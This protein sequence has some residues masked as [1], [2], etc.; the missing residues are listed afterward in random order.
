M[1]IQQLLNLIN[2]RYLFTSRPN[3]VNN[4]IFSIR[5]D[6]TILDYW[7]KVCLEDRLVKIIEHLNRMGPLNC[8]NYIR[9]MQIYDLQQKNCTYVGKH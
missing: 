7:I 8:I 2:I 4:V 5:N 3:R 9:Y 6:R 1:K